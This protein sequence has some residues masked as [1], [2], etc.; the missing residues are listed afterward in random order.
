MNIAIDAHNIRS[1]GGL[2]YLKKILEK[3]NPK[4]N[5]FKKVFIWSTIETL[6]KLP[7]KKWLIKKNNKY[8]VQDKK[9]FLD[10]KVL[11]R[12]FW[13]IFIFKKE[14]KKLNCKVFFF[15]GGYNFSNL[16][17]S[18][19]INL[20]LLPFQNKEI[21]KFGLSLIALRLFIL[22]F[23]QIISANR[24]SGII[25]LSNFMKKIISS[26]LKRKI[27]NKIIYFGIDKIF[28]SK[29]RK[30]KSI[31]N[32][33]KKTPFVI[34]YVSTLFPYKN[35]INVIKAVRM[36][37]EKHFLNIQLLIIGGGYK[38]Y[39]CKVKGFLKSNSINDNKIKYCGYLNQKKL[40]NYLKNK[41]NLKIFASSCE[42]FPNILLEASASGLPI[43]CSNNSPMPEILKTN[44]VYFSPHSINSIY[45]SLLKT[46][47]NTNKRFLMSQK[48]Q[49]FAKNFTWK[50][51]S[52]NTF[53]FLKKCS[54]I[55]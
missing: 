17:P 8:L 11:K 48:S 35:H 40:L 43:V 9:K 41:I 10:L 26:K 51:C 23:I 12:A 46:I 21:Y 22:K 39:V 33:T 20:N 50:K 1:G 3:A 54:K 44:A 31:Y 19:C 25:Y 13:H 14:V 34:G 18:V 49:N 15:P 55:I 5:G 7:K 30:Q 53:L 38:P 28:F 36:L 47:F 6:N 24:S 16:K 37:Q 4:K 52:E 27:N 45:N 32:Y 42:A 29:I 2:L